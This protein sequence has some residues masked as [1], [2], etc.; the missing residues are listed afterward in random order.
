VVAAEEP[1]APAAAGVVRLGLALAEAQ[2]QWAGR[3]GA[4]HGGVMPPSH[5]AEIRVQPN[6]KIFLAELQVYDVNFGT[7]KYEHSALRKYF[8]KPAV[9]DRGAI[10]LVFWC[11][12]F[13]SRFPTVYFQI[14]EM[15]ILSC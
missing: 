14:S 12:Y 6:L 2:W 13:E 1:V 3:A 9:S 15:P 10:S 5:P 8:L 11:P 7:T 4:M